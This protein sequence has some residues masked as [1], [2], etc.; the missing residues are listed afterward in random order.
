[1]EKVRILCGCI[2]VTEVVQ[3]LSRTTF[4]LFKFNTFLKLCKKEN[5]IKINCVCVRVS[6][7]LLK[8]C[9]QGGRHP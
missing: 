2:Y 9:I 8:S 3:T 1:M 7:S 5:L 6:Q 4:E